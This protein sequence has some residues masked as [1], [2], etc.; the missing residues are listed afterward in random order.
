M[1]KGTEIVK[2]KV[3]RSGAKPTKAYEDTIKKSS[4]MSRPVNL[5]AMDTVSVKKKLSK[6][7]KKK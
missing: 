6:I 7:T 2:G 4:R 5:D 1:A 3:I